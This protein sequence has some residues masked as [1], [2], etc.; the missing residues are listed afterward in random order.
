MGGRAKGLL[1]LA[2]TE[3]IV[4]RWIT[5]FRGIGVESVLVGRHADYM[6]YE[7][8]GLRMLDDEPA[9]RGPLGGLIALLRSA[10]SRPAL[11]VACDMPFVS[12]ALLLE[13]AT[14]SEHAPAVAPRRMERWEPLFARYDATRV[15]A[16]AVERQRSGLLSLQGL[17]DE[18]DAVSLPLRR[19][20]RGELD[21]WDTPEDRQTRPG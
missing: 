7:G 21:D 5:L 18:V 4:D 2:S 15:L 11:A 14:F 1:R 13:L 20:E 19:E 12:E 8:R 17:L 3:T 6:H 9:G 10:G 16:A